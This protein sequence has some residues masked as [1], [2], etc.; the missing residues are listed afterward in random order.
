MWI[1]WLTKFHKEQQMR[2]LTIAVL[3]ILAATPAVG[4]AIAQIAE[5]SG[6]QDVATL[7]S[8]LNTL[9]RQAN[10]ADVTG[11]WVTLNPTGSTLNQGL[12]VNHTFAGTAAAANTYA[13]LVSI[14][15]DNADVGANNLWGFVVDWTCC[16]SAAKG[17]R[18]GAGA[19]MHIT[20]ASNVADTEPWYIAVE[21]I[22]AV[23]TAAP[24]TTAGAWSGNFNTI[25]TGAATGW[26]QASSA[27][28]D[29]TVL[30]GAN[31]L[32][33]IALPIV[34][35][36][37][38][39]VQGS[40]TGG[41]AAISFYS[42]STSTAG[43]KN[44]LL[45]DQQAGHGTTIGAS[46]CVL[47]TVGSISMGN[48]LDLSGTTISGNF[49]KGPNGFQVTGTGIVTGTLGDAINQEFQ[50]STS[51]LTKTSNTT[52]G[53]VPGL[54]QT[55][56]AG[57]TYS[58]HG[59]LTG[60]SGAAGGI[61]MLLSYTGTTI[62]SSSFTAMAWAGTTP[63]SNITTTAPSGSLLAINAIYSDIYIDGSIVVNAGGTQA[64]VAAQNT[65]DATSTT[66][67][68]GSTWGCVRVN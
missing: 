28:L 15:S 16:S 57:K 43:W 21:G 41:D 11:T 36:P 33:K 17:Q 48:G 59:H 65:S 50:V 60:V 49:L 62:T 45:L 39:A 56:T 64:I 7:W 30:S 23:S 38:D 35:G 58:C 1:S 24:N 12:V 27:E 9:I 25:L 14:A 34:L 68:Q 32:T 42:A 44:I 37:N 31:P 8:T 47:C 61:K 2:F 53:A 51:T 66:V 54:T 29:M 26:G 18:F 20:G 63:I 19:Y 67:L 46:G 10:K 6:P 52:F 4:T 40:A 3:A 55:L 13:N 5:L 22:N